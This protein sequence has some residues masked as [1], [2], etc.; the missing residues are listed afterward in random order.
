MI[1]E[2]TTPTIDRG[3]ITTYA[4]WKGEKAEHEITIKIDATNGDLTTDSNCGCEYRS[5]Y[6]QSKANRKDRWSCRHILC[7][8]AKTI[9]Q[10]P[11]RAREILI[12]KN[13]INKDHLKKI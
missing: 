5:F 11:R 10:S 4:T 3:I 2:I 8:Y 13:I 6:G 12:K 9:K 7:A 1:K